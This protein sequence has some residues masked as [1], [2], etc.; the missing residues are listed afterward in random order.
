MSHFEKSFLNS[1]CQLD[2]DAIVNRTDAETSVQTQMEALRFELSEQKRQQKIAYEDRLRQK[3]DVLSQTIQE[4]LEDQSKRIAFLEKNLKTLAAK[5]SEQDGINK[6]FSQ[7]EFALRKVALK[8][9]QNE[10]VREGI[11]FQ[12]KEHIGKIELFGRGFL[13]TPKTYDWLLWFEENHLWGK[14]Y[15]ELNN[16]NPTFSARSFRLPKMPQGFGLKQRF[17]VIHWKNGVQ[18]IIGAPLYKSEVS[19]LENRKD[20]KRLMR[21][22][23]IMEIKAAS[24][25]PVSLSQELQVKTKV[26]EK[27]VYSKAIGA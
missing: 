8:N 13:W 21:L 14:A 16:E 22:H 12:L 23:S 20:G 10:K 25:D 15:R 4:V 5:K 2:W 7:K 24:F 18:S 26:G 19:F 6:A 11:K 17:F 9:V 3:D 27:P 1:V